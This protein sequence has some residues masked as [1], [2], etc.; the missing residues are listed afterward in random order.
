MFNYFLVMYNLSAIQ[1]GIQAGHAAME[2]S[3]KYAK[4]AEFQDFVENHKT[5][6]ILDGGTSGDMKKHLKTLR[7]HWR[8]PVAEFREPDLNNS[9][10]AIACILDEDTY[11]AEEGMDEVND[12][13]KQFPLSR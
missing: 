5:F 11:G 10:S 12:F 3:Q 13:F 1:K 7:D 2:Y 9:I 6:I 4:S 8:M